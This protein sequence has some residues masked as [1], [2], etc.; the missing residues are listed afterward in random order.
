M[1]RGIII[2]ILVSLVVLG[3]GQQQQQLKITYL[4]DP[5]GGTLY[6]QNGELWGPCP[7][8]L[9]YDLD[10]EALAARQLQVKG[11]IVRW[12]S[13]PEGRSDEI[14]TFPIDGTDQQFT[15]IQSR[16]V[17]GE[18]RM[19]GPAEK[20]A[21]AIPRV[22][23]AQDPGLLEEPDEQTSPAEEEATTAVSVDD[24]IEERDDPIRAESELDPGLRDEP[25][26]EE[27]PTT[28]AATPAIAQDGV[29]ERQAGA[30]RN[31]GRSDRQAS[32]A[33]PEEELKP[34]EPED[35]HEQVV[36]IK[37]ETKTVDLGDGV[38]IKFALIPEG[39]FMMGV[40]IGGTRGD[41]NENT[42]QRVIISKS[43]YMGVYEVTQ[44][45]YNK[46]M[47]TNPSRFRDPNLPVETVSPNLPVETVSWWDAVAFCKR[48]SEQGGI[49]YRL[50]TE[51]EWEYAC[52]AGTKTAYYWGDDFDDRYA[53][54]LTDRGA[55]TRDVGT[56]LGNAW[57]L[58]DM[59]GNVWE[60]CSDSYG[61]HDE[62]RVLR[63]GSWGHSRLNCRSAHRNWHT[64]NHRYDDCGF[65]IVMEVEQ[66]PEA[67]PTP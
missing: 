10:E 67:P 22:T 35:P 49:E 55:M 44:K 5:P 19:A 41:P 59:S 28:G 27:I 45:Q 24:V 43:F 20:D 31:A 32:V 21:A 4:S 56:K 33:E 60:W 65:R 36:Q 34:S 64:P 1:K 66:T 11:L 2:T 52:R 37:I 57:G 51:A 38:G 16:D 8:V 42:T 9:W 53:W 23:S 15:F 46:V 58:H 47:G 3:C 50:P 61:E 63:G 29:I 39:E 12:P 18:R 7:K 13:G 26:E 40:G 25:D 48:L 6:R 62:F 17:P 14:I 30:G 54:T